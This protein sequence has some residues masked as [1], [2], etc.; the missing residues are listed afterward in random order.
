MPKKSIRSKT[1]RRAP[2]RRSTRTATNIPEATAG[3]HDDTAGGDQPMIINGT[4]GP[5][6]GT[7]MEQFLSR[8]RQEVRAELQQVAQQRQ[9]Q[10]P[11]DHGGHTQDL[12]T[13]GA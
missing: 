4:P 7:E 13:Q 9:Q 8:V 11:Q 12:P 5:L 6:V 3:Q 1:K 10:Q 2:T